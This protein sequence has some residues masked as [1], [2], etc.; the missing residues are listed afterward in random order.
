MKA[1]ARKAISQRP[2]EA[3]NQ[4][5]QQAASGKGCERGAASKPGTAMFGEMRT[6][7]ITLCAPRY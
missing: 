1:A 7:S 3:A 2:A 6:N 4:M 5:T